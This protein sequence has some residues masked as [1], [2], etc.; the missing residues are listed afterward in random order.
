MHRVGRHHKQDI[1]VKKRSKGHHCHLNQ[2]LNT[3]VKKNPVSGLTKM[4]PADSEL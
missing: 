4:P 2:D 3:L 1:Y